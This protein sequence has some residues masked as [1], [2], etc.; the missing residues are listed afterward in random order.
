MAISPTDNKPFTIMS[1]DYNAISSFY[2][3]GAFMGSVGHADK[4]TNGALKDILSID[5]NA[6]VA[7]WQL[8]E[9][10]EGEVIDRVFS[11]QPLI[12]TSDPLFDRDDVDDN[13]KN[14]F[15]LYKGVSRIEELAK[16][17]ETDDGVALAPLLQRQFEGYITEIE[18]FLATAVFTDVDVVSGLKSDTLK[19]TI[20]IPPATADNAHVGTVIAADTTTAITGLTAADEFT[21][22]VTKDYVTTNVTVSLTDAASLGL[23]DIITQIN[24]DL[25]TAGFASTF[26]VKRFTE[27][28]YGLQA[29]IASTEELSLSHAA[30]A[31]SSAV[32]VTGRTGAGEYADGFLTKLNDLGSADP[33]SVFYENISSTYDGTFHD[34]SSNSVA[35]DSHGHVYTVGSTT[36]DMDGQINV[37]GAD[38]FLKKFDAAGN[39]LFTRML[40]SN[41][42][43]TGFSVT[44]DSSD[45][46]IIAGQTGGAL[47]IGAYERGMDN[48]VTKFDSEGEEQWTRQLGPSATDGVLDVTVD[49]SGNIYAAG[50]TEGAIASG[51]T[52]NGGIDAYVTKLDSSG[53]AVFHKQF[54]GAGDEKATAI[55]INAGG[56]ILVAG[57]ADTN[58]FLRKYNASDASLAHD[59][60]LGTIGT[61]GD[62][63]GIAIDSNDDVYVSGF[64][65]DAA[66]SGTVTNAHSGDMDGFVLH[67]DDQASSA[68][69]NYVAYVGTA[70][71]DRNY[72]VAVDV[73]DNS[74][75]V[76]GSTEGTLTG[77]TQ[78]A[79]TDAF[80]AKFDNAGALAY[81]HQFGGGLSHQ[82]FDIAFDADGT[83]TLSKLGLPGGVIPV[84]NS[85]NVGARTTV[86]SDQTFYISVNDSESKVTI[87]SDD[88]FGFLAFKMNKILGSLGLA[89]LNQEIDNRSFQIEALEGSKIQIRKGPGNFNALPG[90]GLIETRLFGKFEEGHRVGELSADEQAFA[91][92]IV[93]GLSL[94]TTDGA[95]AAVTI[96]S[97]AMREIKSAHKFLTVGF[98]EEDE[99]KP[100]G[101]ASTYTLERLAAYEGV[102]AAVQSINSQ[103]LSFASLKS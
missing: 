66:L 48:F 65:T 57:M 31:E 72:G 43:A 68:S 10:K 100:Q 90:M 39:L 28:Q 52:Y 50:F 22:A 35:V 99:F 62:V 64:S 30:A 23:D 40:G 71:S 54:S 47:T 45:N 46:V 77:E 5:P 60:D 69:I 15:A 94:L 80:V 37:D 9:V 1:L 70:S 13:F 82:G 7:P 33:T 27:T 42:S 81:T 34:D 19:S 25:T 84:E 89:S 59:T 56:D 63:T 41:Q 103:P 87:E 79:S 83:N 29:N 26:S 86:R 14:L 91:L 92:G 44:V 58:G 2:S 55:A 8:N 88:T 16:F 51:E 53:T 32:Y 74:F 3:T 24:A 36:G 93:S 20:K 61:S 95:T 17:A 98:Q 12:D 85:L 4:L 11:G 75:Y 6:P 96:M 21:I 38:V 67:L 18:D 73:S 97:N 49:T 102:L 76:T 78:S 101:R